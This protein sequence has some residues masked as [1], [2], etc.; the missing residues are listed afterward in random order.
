MHVADLSSVRR[1]DAVLGRPEH[2]DVDAF[3]LQGLRHLLEL[4]RAVR[5]AVQQDHGRLGAL[6]RAA[7]GAAAWFDDVEGGLAGSP[8]L[9]SLLRLCMGGGGSLLCFAEVVQVDRPRCDGDGDTTRTGPR[10]PTTAGRT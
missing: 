5:E 10:M 3:R 6:S 9:E 8:L 2:D 4:A 7:E 1:R